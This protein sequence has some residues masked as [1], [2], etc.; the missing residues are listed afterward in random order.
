MIPWM[1]EG[2]C[3]LKAWV[4]DCARKMSEVCNQE[5]R[6]LGLNL[7]N[8]QTEGLGTNVKLGGTSGT[9]ISKFKADGDGVLSAPASAPEFSCVSHEENALEELE[10]WEV[11]FPCQLVDDSWVEGALASS[12]EAAHARTTSVRQICRT[13]AEH[14]LRMSLEGVS[15][16]LQERAWIAEVVARHQDPDESTIALKSLALDVPLV[17]SSPTAPEEFLQIR[18]VSRTRLVE[19]WTLL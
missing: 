16:A 11:E 7:P 2:L 18:T 10:E 13:T 6:G 1:G 5:L 8:W 19:S 3:V 9:A 15:R 17:K 14:E 12:E 4:P